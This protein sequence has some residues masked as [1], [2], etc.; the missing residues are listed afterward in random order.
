MWRSTPLK[1]CD[2][3]NLYTFLTY[4]LE[5][6]YRYLIIILSLVSSSISFNKIKRMELQILY[7]YIF[8][9]LWKVIINYYN[10]VLTLGLCFPLK[11]QPKHL[12]KG[13]AILYS[14]HSPQAVSFPSLEKNR[15]TRFVLHPNSSYS[16]LFFKWDSLHFGWDAET[17]VI[18]TPMMS[19]LDNHFFKM[20]L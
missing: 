1:V 3:C 4:S 2:Q 19:I 5:L 13:N 7:T 20:I 8:P 10:K 9:F 17:H 11:N 12:K 14:C 18:Q 16:D 6:Y 15:G